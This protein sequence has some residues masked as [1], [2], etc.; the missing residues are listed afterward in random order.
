LITEFD[1]RQFLSKSL[2]ALGAGWTAGHWPAI[3]LAADH[4][5]KAAASPEPQ[6]WEFFTPE[7]AREVEAIASAIIP[8]D[9]TPGAREAG[10]VYFIDRAL[11]TFAVDDQKTYRQGLPEIQKRVKELF[12]E[13]SSFSRASSEQQEAVLESLDEAGAKNPPRRPRVGFR[14]GGAQPLFE[15]LRAHTLAGFLIDPE[16]DRKGNRGGVGWTAIGR[17]PDHTFEPPF[18]YYDKDYPGW[19]PQGKEAD[20]K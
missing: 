18:G 13:A 12:P 8:T 4:A 11:V 20:K 14:A 15:V 1:R 16:S 2:S 17:A 6:P 9:S 3:L 19:Q 7:E 5:H 10:V